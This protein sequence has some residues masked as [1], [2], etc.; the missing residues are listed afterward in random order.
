VVRTRIGPARLKLD[1]LRK[2]FADELIERV[3]DE[4]YGRVE[5]ADADQWIDRPPV[6]DE[7]AVAAA[8]AEKKIRTFKP[9]MEINTKRRKLY[10]YLAR[11]G[12]APEVAR[13]MALDRF[14]ELADDAD[15]GTVWT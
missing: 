6:D 14:D 10:D 5:P 12:F 7:E 13:R 1:L 3:V 11:R 8:A 9:G 2:G 4:V 15:K